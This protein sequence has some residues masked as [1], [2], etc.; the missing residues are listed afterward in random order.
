MVTLPNEPNSGESPR[1]IFGR[2]LRRFRREAGLS[3]EQLAAR[4]DYTSAQISAVENA[5]R[6]PTEA[7]TK[8]C[9]EVLELGGALLR[10]WPAAYNQAAPS[11]FRPFLDLEREATMLRSWEPLVFPGLLQTEDYA[12]AI[13]RGEPRSTS[14][15]VE[16]QVTARMERQKIFGRP[17]PPMY[18]VVLDEGVLHRI[19]GDHDVMIGQLKHLEELAE[20]PH[21]SIQ[22]LPF[23]ARSTAGLEGGFVVAQTPGSPDTGYIE[24]VG[25]GQLVDRVEEVRRIVA[26][27]EVIRAEALPRR[28][29]LVQIREIREAME[30]N[31]EFTQATWKKSSHSGGSGGNC[32]E[33]A[34]LTGGRRAV[35]DS[36]DLTVPAMVVEAGA[37]AA[38]VEG[39]RNDKF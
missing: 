38:F 25:H 34:G 21:I 27:Y 35:R 10:L 33:V 1:V 26:K 30:Q 14:E 19:V 11:W 20:L 36:K 4:I 17:E 28:A 37:W 6:A 39:V 3:Q 32:V 7:F 29:S 2:E 18:W 5:R 15:M 23:S 8:L 31:A 22:I 24:A 9:D 12:R 13:F 16:K